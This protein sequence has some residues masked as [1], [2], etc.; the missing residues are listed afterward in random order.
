MTRFVSIALL[1][2]ATAC[3][4]TV[5]G[6]DASADGS[7]GDGAGADTSTD[8]EWTQCR[9]PSGAELCGSAAKCGANCLHC[10]DNP[11]EPGPGD[12]GLSLCNDT[13][14]SGSGEYRQC[15]D[16]FVNVAAAADQPTNALFYYC[17]NEDAAKLYALAGRPDLARFPDR[18]AW[19]DA[20]IPAPPSTCPTGPPGLHLCGGAC[21]DCPSPSTQVCMGR[22]PTHPYSLCVNR[23]GIKKSTPESCKRGNGGI[24]QLGADLRCLTF[25]VEGSSQPVADA[26]SMCVDP[27]ICMAAEAA[28]PGGAFCTT[29]AL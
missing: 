18:S 9:A 7:P 28:Y 12:S 29:G 8:G 21:G 27:D 19:T 26:F 22:S 14:I 25:K 15:P 10:T 4:G 2:L 5:A 20:G 6:A 13:L 24:C 11:W 23:F 16:G 1:V 3:G 17:R